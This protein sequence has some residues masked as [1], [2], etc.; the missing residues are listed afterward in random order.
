[1]KEVAMIAL[2]FIVFGG[3]GFYI[4]RPLAVAI[5]KRIA[6]EVPPRRDPE[7]DE[8]ILSELRDLR[9][10]MTALAERVDFT[11]RMLAKQREPDRLAPPR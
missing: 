7:Q 11:E 3:G 9:E 8:A 2:M 6:G 5:A 1:M 4:L 10:E